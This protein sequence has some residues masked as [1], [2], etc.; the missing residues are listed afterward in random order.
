[1]DC[2]GLGDII[3]CTVNDGGHG[4]DH[5]ILVVDDGVDRLVLDDV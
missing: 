1:M 3:L 2:Y 5:V 4:E